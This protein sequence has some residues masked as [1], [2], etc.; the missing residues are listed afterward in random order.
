MS[1]WVESH[2]RG[3]PQLLAAAV[4]GRDRLL[5]RR[6]HGLLVV[7]KQRLERVQR[8]EMKLSRQCTFP[9]I[10]QGR[11]IMTSHR[12]DV[13]DARPDSSAHGV[14]AGLVVE[15]GCAQAH[16]GNLASLE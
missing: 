1:P 8:S 3:H 15:G 14:D 2:L 10:F 6:P 5:D 16:R 11:L 12:V 9:I 13:P 4:A 7:I